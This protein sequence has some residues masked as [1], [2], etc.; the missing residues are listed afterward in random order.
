[1][2][3]LFRY[4]LDLTGSNPD[5]FVGDEKHVLSDRR[6]R[7]VVT[8]AGP[9]YADN[10]VM[11]DM[12]DLR[13]LVR[14]IDYVPIE[15]NQ[16][17]SL[18]TGK[19]VFGALLVI[20]RQ[21]SKNIQVSYQCVGGEWEQTAQ[22]LFDLLD[23]IP[24]DGLDF[25][26]YEIDGKPK[27]W[28][29][30]PHFHPIGTPSGFEEI[31]HKLDKIQNAI[32]YTDLPAYKNL[33]LYI[34][35]IID[36]IN[37]K[38]KYKMDAFFGPQLIA[39]KR[40]IN[41]AFFGLDN[42]SNYGIA[43]EEDGRIIA[44]SDSITKNFPVAKYIALNSLIAF[45]NVLYNTFIL[46]ET[47]HIGLT[48][49]TNVSPDADS[50]LNLRTGAIRTLVSKAQASNG[51]AGINLSI[52]PTD[53]GS[54][55]QFVITKISGNKNNRGGIYFLIERTGKKF[56]IVKHSSG[57]PEV[58]FTHLRIAMYP[59][60]E[61]IENR[62]LTH[63]N[64]VDN[65]HD[66]TKSQIGLG[67]VENLPII[68]VQEILCLDNARKYITFDLFLLFVK[69]FFIG[70][71]E[72]DDEDRSGEINPIEQ[73]D[74][75]KCG[76]GVL[77]ECPPCCDTPEPPPPA[78]SPEPEPP[79]PVQVTPMVKKTQ[80]CSP[81]DNSSNPSNENIKLIGGY[82]YEGEEDHT[83]EADITY[84]SSHCGFENVDLHSNTNFHYGSYIGEEVSP[85]IQGFAFWPIDRTDS[86]SNTYQL[87]V[88]NVIGDGFIRTHTGG[89]RIPF[90]S[91]Y[92]DYEFAN[93][94]KLYIGHNP[95]LLA[96]D[97]Q[98]YNFVENTCDYDRYTI[99]NDELFIEGYYGGGGP[100]DNY[101]F[102]I[103][104]L[105][106][107]HASTGRTIIPFVINDIVSPFN[108]SDYGDSIRVRLHLY[109]LGNDVYHSLNLDY[110]VLNADDSNELIINP[111]N[112]VAHSD[113]I[114]IESVSSGLI[115][116]YY[117]YSYAQTLE[118]I[119]L[120]IP[121]SAVGYSIE[122]DYELTVT[123]SET[124][125]GY[126]HDDLLSRGYSNKFRFSFDSDIYQ[127]KTVPLTDGNGITIG[128]VKLVYN[129]TKKRLSITDI[130]RPDI[131]EDNAV[132]SSY[133]YFA[134]DNNSDYITLIDDTPSV[135]SILAFAKN[136]G[137]TISSVNAMTST[138][139]LNKV[140]TGED[141]FPGVDNGFFLYIWKQHRQHG[142][143]NTAHGTLEV[144]STQF[145]SITKVRRQIWTFEQAG[146]GVS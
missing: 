99:I 28:F 84:W 109:N 18:R 82:G 45:K 87:R 27:E 5:N 130:T 36:E 50:I 12:A 29:P 145:A 83:V 46:S 6:N 40:Q 38:N 25:S 23:K 7:A 80:W 127:S 132:H 128:N 114:D 53:A 108:H 136:L 67:L 3:P 92:D 122:V 15:L 2:Q 64:D 31:C 4:G 105:E 140:L 125:E 63:I 107:D 121:K 134:E 19:D 116:F 78:P 48:N 89:N 70:K 100:D 117:N 66:T 96:D 112:I 126:T 72:G 106:Y 102:N 90:T 131:S 103:D 75:Y 55:E 22:T 95:Q 16:I 62:L 20:N 129:T 39:F 69:T 139:V 17:M 143:L 144:S 42:L 59:Q 60:F 98:N 86:S 104:W 101:I 33:I 26:W 146:G 76:T 73:L 94:F 35:S 47:T 115:E 124:G 52:Y 74:I 133:V 10:V 21:V 123:L 138:D 30:T 81:L 14:G 77:E 11:V 91:Y 71:N 58:H 13:I 8:K 93:N 119:D 97:E 85:P 79:P 41:T 24:D 54:S 111:S 51:S 118:W 88:K 137:V 9:F 49:T 141:I 32:S 57:E 135:Y 68:S 113:G 44:R 61:D 65:G 37:Q 110:S 34:N 43:T 56:Y 120:A 1:M 142:V